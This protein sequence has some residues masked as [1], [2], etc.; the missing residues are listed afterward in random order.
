MKFSHFFIDRP[1]FATVLSL[2][3][4]IVGGL[5]VFQI[6]VSEFPNILPPTIVV[7][8]RYPG[9]NPQVLADT[10]ASPIEQEVNGVEDM[11]YMSAQC[12]GDG[13]MT[14]TI[15]F[16]LGTDIDKA[17][18]QVQNRVAVAE[19]KLPEEVRRFGV[20]T[21]KRSP[22]ITLVVNIISPDGRY[23]KLYIDNYANLQVKDALARLPGVGNITIFGARDYSMR[24]WLDP[25]KVASRGLTASDVV[26]AIREQNVQV[27]AGILGQPP[28][29]EGVP[30]QFTVNAQGRLTDEEQFGEIV[31]KT[32][33]DG[34]VTRV[35]DVAR[36]ELAA[37]DYS[38]NSGLGG[39]PA[40]A[41]AIFQLPGS[42]A[43]ATSDAVRKKMAERS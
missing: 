41:I 16:K 14:L 33:A 39:K 4:V 29:S 21:A 31:I 15:T 1:I 37:R 3:I 8:A 2:V 22:D 27:A 32:G 43:L 26:N 5:A 6:P 19:P 35:R 28:M 24:V 12:A 11:L 9:A 30:F 20:T 40:T 25:E 13:S 42:N 38:V 23:D 7:T 34:Q 36:V 18:V 17:Q 10:V